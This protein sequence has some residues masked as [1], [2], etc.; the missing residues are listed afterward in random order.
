[1]RLSAGCKNRSKQR[2]GRMNAEQPAL[3][4]HCQPETSS[5]QGTQNC[6]A[7]RTVGG[8]CACWASDLVPC[9]FVAAFGP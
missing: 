3:A 2:S 7:V 9:S 8:R 4:L 1:M 5:L 6:C